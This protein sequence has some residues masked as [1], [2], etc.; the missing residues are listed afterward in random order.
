MCKAPFT[1]SLILLPL[2]DHGGSQ[3]LWSEAQSNNAGTAARWGALGVPLLFVAWH[4]DSYTARTWTAR[5][6]ATRALC[7]PGRLQLGDAY[8]VPAWRKCGAS[9]RDWSFE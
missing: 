8:R 2:A 6:R 9:T 1:C 5:Q 7:T 4:L 3:V